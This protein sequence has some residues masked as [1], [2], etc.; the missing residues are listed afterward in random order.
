MS[1]IRID[2]PKRL[3]ALAEQMNGFQYA[4]EKFIENMRNAVKTTMDQLTRMKIAMQNKIDAI[5]NDINDLYNN[6]SSYSWPED[7]EI[8]LDIDADIKSLKAQKQHY[9]EQKKKIDQAYKNIDY[10][11]KRNGVKDREEKLTQYLQRYPKAI[12]GLFEMESIMMHYLKYSSDIVKTSIT[13]NEYGG[14]VPNSN[15]IQSQ[16]FKLY[17][18]E[19]NKDNREFLD[20]ITYGRLKSYEPLTDQILS[21]AEFEAQKKKA[22]IL[23]FEIGDKDIELCQKAGYI[24]FEE[25]VNGLIP[26]N[27][28]KSFRQTFNDVFLNNPK[29]IAKKDMHNEIDLTGGLFKGGAIY[30]SSQEYELDN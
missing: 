9:I 12:D 11:Y 8:I 17:E 7:R 14:F 19:V 20:R 23:E 6:R 21:N 18:E 5:Q 13:G 26:Y 3:L 1:N 27:P 2:N 28:N 25:T 15:S 29:L 22:K 4:F 30:K 10:Q 16:N 24:V